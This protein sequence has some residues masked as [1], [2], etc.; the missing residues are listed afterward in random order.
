MWWQIDGKMLSR[1]MTK[2][3]L[4][5]FALSAFAFLGYLILNEF[6]HNLAQLMRAFQR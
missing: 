1:V 2:V 3:F 5:L 4:V 6:L